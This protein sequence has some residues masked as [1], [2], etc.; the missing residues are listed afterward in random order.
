MTTGHINFESLGTATLDDA[1]TAWRDSGI[2]VPTP[3]DEML[4]VQVG[5]LISHAFEAHRLTRTDPVTPGASPGGAGLPL[6][7]IASTFASDR[8]GVTAGGNLAISQLGGPT[9]VNLWH[10]VPDDIA[11][12]NL[13]S[14]VQT[15]LLPVPT[16]ATRG[17]AVKQS[18]EG[19]TYELVEDD[20]GQ[21]GGV[22]YA[23]WEQ[24]Q[25]RNSA[26]ADREDDV[27]ALLPAVSRL[28]DRRLK[29]MPGG[30]APLDNQTFLFS[31]RGTRTLRLRDSEGALY[32]LRSVDADGIRP[33]YDRTGDYDDAPHQWDLDDAWIWPRPRNGSA[34]GRPYRSL[35]LRRIST[36]P[37]TIWPYLDGG[38]RIAGDWGWAA[39]PGMIRELV[40]AWT[41]DAA[42][43]HQGG[44]SA[45]VDGMEEPVML[46]GDTWRLWRKVEL[47]YGTGDMAA[48]GVRV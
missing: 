8:I 41:R 14:S 28:V 10:L 18:A 21:S 23:T 35:E 25:S 37:L 48:L 33:D 20:V 9:T 46:G 12:R 43:A 40:I 19:E 44:L 4:V 42:D 34:L 11:E 30:F 5:S 13:A 3:D 27:T 47:E 39:V 17:Y 29:M 24:Y 1:G 16:P 7:E 22:A 36:A 31:S 45:V 38:V 2:T 32:P 15:R 6:S 26:N